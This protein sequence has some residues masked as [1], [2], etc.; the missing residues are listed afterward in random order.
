MFTLWLII[1]ICLAIAYFLLQLLFYYQWRQTETITNT[2]NS[3]NTSV[4]I[5]IPARNEAQNISNLL[6]AILQQDFPKE[7][8][9]IIVVD[10]CSEVGLFCL[11]IWVVCLKQL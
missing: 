8:I 4:A 7:L 9:E 5:I 6:D 11:S 10:D 2:E 1:S 3:V